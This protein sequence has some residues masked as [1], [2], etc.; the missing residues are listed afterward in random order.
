MSMILRPL[1]VPPGL[2]GRI[3][4]SA[5]PGRFE[6]WADFLTAARRAD[7][8]EIVC[9]T[10]WHE[11]KGLSPAY[12]AALNEGTLP[13]RW[14]N[15][16]IRNLGV[17]AEQQQFRQAIDRL[18]GHVQSGDSVLLHC[19]AGIGRTGTAAACLLKCLGASAAESVER[20]RVAGSNPESAAQSGLIALF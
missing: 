4:L 13:L 5:M 20:V 8:A 15:L 7:L 18:A 11:I 1:E 17:P 14:S 16:P 9:L 6:H 19:A 2:P 3:W 12:A 10:P